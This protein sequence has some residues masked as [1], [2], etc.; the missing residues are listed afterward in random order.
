MG[1]A[2]GAE[3]VPKADT[4]IRADGEIN[5]NKDGGR[6]VDGGRWTVWSGPLVVGEESPHTKESW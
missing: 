6:W 2:Q 3:E 1:D 4:F 5:L